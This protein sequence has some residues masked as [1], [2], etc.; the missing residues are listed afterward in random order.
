MAV[1]TVPLTVCVEGES[2][3][4]GAAA[5]VMVTVAVALLRSRSVPVTVWF[6]AFCV[7][8]GVPLI[9]PVSVFN[10]SP[11]GNLGSTS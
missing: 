1:P 6:V 2:A 4:G 9:T 7:A 5:M 10:D 3:A 11:G 8:V